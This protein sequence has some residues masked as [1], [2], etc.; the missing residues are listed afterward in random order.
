[1][2]FNGQRL[3]EEDFTT[4]HDFVNMDVNPVKYLGVDPGKANGVCGYNSQYFLA[5]MWTIQEDDILDFLNQFENVDTCVIEN[6]S[7]YPN[8]A[9]QQV[10]SDMVT[11]RVIGRFEGWAARKEV[12]LV[13]QP[14]NIKK[15]GYAWIGQKQPSKSDP[16]N[17]V[18]DAN[19]HFM[20]WAVK[21]GKVD[22]RILLELNKGK[23]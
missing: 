3:T 12:K 6:Y 14:A 7:L 9:M 23:R 22:A 16:Q 19:V 15:V 11:S 10:Y 8:K 5:F 4:I 18:K 2:N 21:S 13:K 17:H 1:V 20:Y